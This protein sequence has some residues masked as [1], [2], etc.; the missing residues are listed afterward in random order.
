VALSVILPFVSAPLIWFTCRAQYMKVAVRHDNDAQR[1]AVSDTI[2]DEAGYVQMRNHW[3]TTGFAV[4]VWGV[5]VV[6]NVA[7]LVFAGMGVA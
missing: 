4:V 6:M 7:A 1:H 2:H 3:I 5:I